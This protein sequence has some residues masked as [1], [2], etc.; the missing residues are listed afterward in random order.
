MTALEN[1]EKDMEI[2]KPDKCFGVRHF[3]YALLFV[4]T[5]IAYGIRTIL[6]VAVIAMIS[7]DPPDESVPGFLYPSIHNLLSLWAPLSDRATVATFV[8]AG[9][10]LGN[11]IAMPITGAIAASTVGW[12][13]VFYLYGTMGMVWSI[14]WLFTGS[15]SPSKCKGI[16][17]EEKKYIDAGLVSEDRKTVPTPW[18]SILTSLPFLAILVSHFGQNWGFWTLLTEIPSYM[19]NILH[20]KIASNSYLSALPYLVLWLLSLVMSPLADWL[21]RRRIV[22]LEGSRKIFN[23]IGLFVPAFALFALLLVDGTQKTTTIFILVIAVGF[24]AGQFSG[25]HLNHIDISPT[26]SGTLMGITN[27]LSNIFGI[28]APLAVDAVKSVSG[29]AE[30]DKAMWNII[31]CITAVIYIV[32]GSFYI[33]G[34]SGSVQAWDHIEVNE[35]QD[36]EKNMSMPK[37]DVQKPEKWFGVRHAQYILYSTAAFS[38]YSLRISFNVAIIAMITDDPPGENIPTYPEWSSS[39]NV[40]ISAF[41]WGYVATQLISSQ[42]AARYGPKWILAITFFITSLFSILIPAFGEAFGY[43]GVIACRVIQG[44]SQ[45]FLFPCLQHLLG[46]WTSTVGRGTAA[47]VTFVGVSLGTVISMP[48][49][50][51]LCN[52]ASVGWPAAYYVFGALGILWTIVWAIFGCNSPGQHKTIS[53]AE[54]HYIWGGEEPEYEKPEKKPSTPWIAI[55][56]SLPFWAIVIND[57]GFSWGYWTLLSEIPSYMQSILNFDIASNGFLSALPYFVRSCFIIPMGFLSDHLVEKKVTSPTVNRKIFNSIAMFVGAIGL[58]CLTLID[59]D[60]RSA[61]IAILVIA[62]AFTGGI[63]SGFILS[64]VDLSPVHAGTVMG[65]S[66]TASN[67]FSLLGPLSVDFVIHTTGYQETDKELWTIIFCTA[68][69]ILAAVGLFFIYG[70]SGKAQY[71]NNADYRK[72]E[73]LNLSDLVGSVKFFKSKIMV[74][75]LCT[76]VADLPVSLSNIEVE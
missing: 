5:I 29:Q 32:T 42:L 22:S 18:R 15:D 10:P 47:S 36:I 7:D 67:F 25:F 17:A 52:S 19:E 8:Y 58:A 28:L 68:S 31:F 74:N 11:V 76:A 48:V 41:F 20:F 30:T 59:G 1:T 24:N 13:V 27:S 50:G 75:T 40:M 37:A 69:V 9:G 44:L 55:L 46:R 6:N 70:G 53:A 54:K 4:G 60:Q 23:T 33:Y 12:P 73:K 43:R 35:T 63:F 49:T 65:I 56:T 51:L 66:N 62:V 39:K 34:G 71:W 14:L 61:T 26:H 64:Q 16:S 38:G 45:G 72:E 57:C 3:Q 2:Q 21:I